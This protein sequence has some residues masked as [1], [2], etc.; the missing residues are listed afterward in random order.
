M[1]LHTRTVPQ[2]RVTDGWIGDAEI[3]FE[4]SMWQFMK[5]MVDFILTH[6][7]G[8]KDLR[9]PVQKLTTIPS[10]MPM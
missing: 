7:K 2:E 9:R 5:M 10:N 3:H 4:F 1:V 6:L 8:G